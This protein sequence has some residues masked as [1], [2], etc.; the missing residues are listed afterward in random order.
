M[1]SVLLLTMSDGS[2]TGRFPLDRYITF[3]KNGPLFESLLHIKMERKLH[4]SFTISNGYLHKRLCFCVSIRMSLILESVQSILY[5]ASEVG[6]QCIRCFETIEDRGV[7]SRFAAARK[8]FHDI[9]AKSFHPRA[10]GLGN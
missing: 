7:F 6:T 2:V 3:G 4:L 1:V 9:L 8:M 5:V 10:F